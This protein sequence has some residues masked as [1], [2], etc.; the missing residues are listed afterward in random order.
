MQTKRKR[1]NYSN[2]TKIRRIISMLFCCTFLLTCFCDMLVIADDMR[3][4]KCTHSHTEEC[5]TRLIKCVLDTNTDTDADTDIGDTNTDSETDKT[6]LDARSDHTCSE[7]SGCITKIL[8]CTHIHDETCGYFET[9]KEMPVISWSWVD[10]EELLVLDKQTG[11]WRLGLPGTSREN[12]LTEKLLTELLPSEIRAKLTDGAERNI[13]IEWKLSDFPVE[14]LYRGQHKITAALAGGYSLDESAPVLEVLLDLGGAST[15]G[16]DNGELKTTLKDYE[17]EQLPNHMLNTT[18]DRVV[19]NPP[20]TVVNLFNYG[21]TGGVSPAKNGNDLLSQTTEH[22]RNQDRKSFGAWP[23][24]AT[25]RFAEPGDWNHGINRNHFIIFGNAVIAHAGLWNRGAGAGNPYGQVLAGT[26]G[27]VNHVLG[28]NGFPSINAENARKRLDSDPNSS[29]E[30][31]KP[32]YTYY[33]RYESSL[34]NKVM[35]DFF[36]WELLPDWKVAGDH[37]SINGKLFKDMPDN[38][39][40]LSNTLIKNWQEA[41]GKQ[42]GTGP[43]QETESLSYLFDPNEAHNLKESYSD[44]KGLFQLDDNGYYYY[45]MRKNFAE[46]DKANNKFILYDAPATTNSLDQSAG[47]FL[48]FNKGAEVFTSILNGKLQSNVA[49]GAVGIDHYFGLTVQTDFRQPIGGKVSN[50]KNEST[51]MTFEFSGDD[52]VWI[53]VDDVL[54]LDLGGVHSEIYGTINFSTGDVHVGRSFVVDG[55]GRAADYDNANKYKAT[56]VI[57]KG[58][59][60]DPSNPAQMVH[61]YKLR[62]LFKAAGKEDAVQWTGDTFASHT[63]HTIKLFYLERG[64]YDSS[65]TLRFNLVPRL[66]QQIKKVDQDGSPLAGVGFDLYAAEEVTDADGNTNYRETGDVLTSLVTDADGIAQFREGTESPGVGEEDERPPFNFSDRFAQQGQKFYILKETKAPPGYRRLPTDIILEFDNTT[67]M[68]TVKNRYQ[69]GSY[70]SFISTIVGNRNITYG[71][72]NEETGDINRTDRL[73]TEE[74]QRDGLVVAIPMLYEHTSKKWKAL[75]GSN[76]TG[77]QSV[78]PESRTAEDWRTACLTAMLWQCSDTKQ[79]VPKWYLAWDSE[80]KNLVGTLS[81]LPGSANRYLLNNAGG[82]M[83]MVYALIRREA[84]GELGIDYKNMKDGEVYAAIGA[85]VNARISEGKKTEEAISEIRDII[86]HGNGESRWFYSLNTD[87]FA[88]SFRSLIYIP[89]ERRELRVWKVDQTGQP[90][91]GVEFSLFENA[92]CTGTAIATGTTANVDGRD[93]VLVFTPS[94]KMSGTSVS[95]GYSQMIWAEY[96]GRQYYLKETDAPAGYR[97]NETVVPVHVG[98][99]S[100]YADAGTTADGITVMTEVG[101]LAQTMKKY[102]ADEEVNITLRDIIATAQTQPAGEFELEGWQEMKLEGTDEV[103]RLNLHYGQNALIDYGIH[104]EDGGKTLYPYFV[105]DHGFIT[106]RVKQ[107]EDALT[108]DAPYGD[109]QNNANHDLLGDMDITGLFSLVNIVVVT[110]TDMNK[111]DYGSLTISKRIEGPLELIRDDYDRN[112][113]Y[114]LDLTDKDGKPINADDQ[115]Y[116]YGKDKS[117]YIKNGG[118]FFLHHDETFT[119][120]GLPVGTHYAVT[121]TPDSAGQYICINGTVRNGVI[122]AS[123]SSDTAAE[124]GQRADFVNVRNSIK[125]EFIKV[126]AYHNERVLPGATFSLYR[127]VGEGAADESTLIPPDGTV[128]ATRWELV[129]STESGEDGMV[130]FDEYLTADTYRLVEKKAP[131]GYLRPKSQWQFRV[132]LGESAMQ[133]DNTS[134]QYVGER[135]DKPPAFIIGDSSVQDGVTVC[136]FLLPNMPTA[137]L[138]FTGGR[139][140]MMFMLFGAGLIC[141]ASPIA[142][143]YCANN[144]RKQRVVKECG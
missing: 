18:T 117:G 120:L 88:R 38:V 40:N 19:D 20:N 30:G 97:L 4:G 101:K 12:P 52:D 84:L 17:L 110:D 65:L 74:D 57:T 130:H 121:E 132:I 122:E 140:K 1:S 109:S 129:A 137:D 119:I 78:M 14:G 45:D 106:V 133:I 56:H 37:D 70:A 72:F 105:T 116:F 135:N 79:N 9:P 118:T 93:G 108:G 112:F 100:I 107:N 92:D 58:I 41:T 7:E 131:V 77:L 68:L 25:M 81:D 94:P 76:V 34:S 139:S 42:F 141:T 29:T 28:A 35:G 86:L 128:D 103:R 2:M 46:F 24:G 59:P 15:T 43:N 49:S 75:Y 115:F 89:N 44:V 13:Q 50:D 83:K 27:I 63:D 85:A 53:F 113:E 80:T 91:N 62:D 6:E 16:V 125:F 82:D 31:Q 48:P 138:P 98:V 123:S 23:S 142:I 39:Q 126:D 71:A 51:D 60:E 87:Q 26:E 36:G 96:E 54:V 73:V 67:S 55:V 134:F 47:N 144:S 32:P 114:R 102:A 61:S 95:P 64:N 10:G 136:K 3:Y 69:S 90:V 22:H 143:W 104:D 66:F 21:V 127:W 33:N 11:T 99:Y 5:Y 124:S 8:Q 111:T